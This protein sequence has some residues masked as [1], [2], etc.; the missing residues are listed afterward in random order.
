[1]YLQNFS[2]Q[3]RPLDE[4]GCSGEPS[5]K[6]PNMEDETVPE[7]V[8]ETILKKLICCMGETF[9][10]LMFLT[11]YRNLFSKNKTLVECAEEIV[12]SMGSQL[13]NMYIWVTSCDFD[14][15][16]NYRHLHGIFIKLIT[17]YMF[18]VLEHKKTTEVRCFFNNNRELYVKLTDSAMEDGIP[19]FFAGPLHLELVSQDGKIFYKATLRA[20]MRIDETF[21]LVIS[22]D[23]SNRPI[24]L[25]EGSYGFVFKVMGL[26]GKWYVV[27][28]FD[29]KHSAE[30]EWALLSIFS[31]KHECLQNG[32]ALRTEQSGYLLNHYIVSEYQG[33]VALSNIKKQR[34]KKILLDAILKGFLEILPALDVMHKRGFIHGDIKPDNIVWGKQNDGKM[35][36]IDFGIATQIGKTIGPNSLFT[37]LFRDIKLMLA[38][39]MMKEFNTMMS[40]IVHPITASPEMDY[41]AFF[42]T[43]LKTLS[44]PSSGFIFDGM[45]EDYAREMLYH[46][47]TVIRLMK[48]LKPYLSDKRGIEF[49]QQVYCVLFNE[50]GPEEFIRIFNSFELSLGEATYVD[51]LQMFKKFR[52]KNPMKELVSKVFEHMVYRDP[53]INE[54][55]EELRVLR[56]NELVG[57]LRVLFVEIICDGADFSLLGLF[58]KSRIDGWL[59]RLS[60]IATKF[61]ELNAD[62]YFY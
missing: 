10:N 54:L 19:V 53:R 21:K 27:K 37:W 58:T 32:I 15:T 20:E 52:E 61:C 48:K 47:S 23:S 49:V 62:V 28:V 22:K 38:E 8:P 3:K 44:Q 33:E 24:F 17:S 7:T 46:S 36:L 31:G 25:G 43:I 40:T 26:D 35:V 34:D 18:Y 29:D 1:M 12:A 30:Q 2:K 60:Q 6:Q 59:M 51:Y 14:I 9:A 56:I 57:E 11:I 13:A 45:T 50:E 42:M 39:K 4:E 41:W 55:V 5:P 16:E